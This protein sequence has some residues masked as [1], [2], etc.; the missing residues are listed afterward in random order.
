MKK[1]TWNFGTL[2]SNLYNTHVKQALDNSIKRT[3]NEIILAVTK[4]IETNL[5]NTGESSKP[6]VI[7]YPSKQMRLLEHESYPR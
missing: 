3:V 7:S 4:V 5:N 2:D 6:L 1:K